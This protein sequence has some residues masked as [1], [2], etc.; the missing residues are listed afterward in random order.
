MRF[1]TLD[2]LLTALCMAPGAFAAI[3]V[4][5]AFGPHSFLLVLPACGLTYLL[6]SPLIYRL[7][8]LCVLWLPSCPKCH[9][10]NRHYYFPVPRFS[11]PRDFAVCA[12]C[13]AKLELWYRAPNAEGLSEGMT[14]FLLRWPQSWGRWK[15]MEQHRPAPP[16]D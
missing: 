6:L 8:R 3:G 15:P 14:P 2:L 9:D 1:N 10:K 4:C 13:G 5:R 11:W 7:L 16:T 12:M